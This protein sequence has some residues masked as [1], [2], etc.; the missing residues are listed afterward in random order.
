MR[1]EGTRPGTMGAMVAAAI[2]TSLMDLIAGAL[3]TIHQRRMR[4][5]ILPLKSPDI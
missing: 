2:H 4:I 1:G 3:V 5:T